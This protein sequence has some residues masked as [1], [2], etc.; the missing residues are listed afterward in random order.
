M[1]VESTFTV[2]QRGVGKPDYSRVV[3]SARER[4]GISAKYNQ[5]LLIFARTFS[6]T[7]SLMN[8]ARVP[9]AIGEMDH[10]VNVADGNL[11]PFITPP[12][13]TFTSVEIEYGGTQDVLSETFYDPT[14]PPVGPQMAITE[15]LAGGIHAYIQRI[16]AFTTATLDPTGALP[17][18]IDIQITNL[19][20]AELIGGAT[21]LIILEK[22]GSEP[23]PTT[24]TVVCKFCGNKKTVP[25]DT[26]EVICD[27][28]DKLT[29]YQNLSHFRETP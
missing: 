15:I 14:I 18:P 22:V 4:A 11:M 8:W 26:S 2:T 25:L 17:H 24:K 1:R 23:L 3:S 10:L 29:I 12:G 9:L 13:Y 19:G 6:N 21:I 16:T 20:G 27:K 28:C 7:P 5:T